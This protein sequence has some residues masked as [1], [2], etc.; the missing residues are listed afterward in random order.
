MRQSPVSN[1]LDDEKAY[2]RSFR[3]GLLAAAL[4][5]GLCLTLF[6]LI[7]YRAQMFSFYEQYFPTPTLTHTSTPTS[8]PTLTAT[9]TATFTSTPNLTATQSALL[10]TQTALAVESL[11]TGVVEQWQHVFSE[12]FDNNRESWPLDAEDDQYS[13]T[14]YEIKDGKYRLS[15]SSHQ[16]FIKWIPIPSS[17]VGDF[18]LTVEANLVEPSDD[19]D[20]GIVFRWDADG[21]FYFF[22]VDPRG[23]YGLYK[24]VGSD[25][26]TLVDS[27]ET[28]L[29]RSDQPNRLGV[30]AQ[31]NTFFLFIND[32]FVAETQDDSIKK[33]STAF[34]YELFQPNENATFEFDNVLVHNP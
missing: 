21:N 19:G 20:Y 4:F 25:W 12:S 7:G 29:I 31:G 22:E 28:T 15:A 30:I 16:S 8:P 9:P 5:I 32:Q 2:T 26:T 23:T 24:Y 34:A 13:K 11:A 18:A 3:L 14:T 1:P 17:E 27:T 33:G 10:T 6:G